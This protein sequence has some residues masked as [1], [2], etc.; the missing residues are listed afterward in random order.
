[1]FLYKDYADY[2]DENN[3][4]DTE[5]QPCHKILTEL[6][7]EAVAFGSVAAVALFLNNCI[8]G[9][10]CGGKN[11]ERKYNGEENL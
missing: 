8:C 1:M 6:Y 4:D 10:G 3:C 11:Y 2:C 7:S 9:K 5:E